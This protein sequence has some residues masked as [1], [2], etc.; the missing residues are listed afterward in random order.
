MGPRLALIRSERRRRSHYFVNITNGTR[1][2]LPVGAQALSVWL[3]A[4][5]VC[6]TVWRVS[7]LGDLWLA[8][9]LVPRASVPLN[10]GHRT[11]FTKEGEKTKLS[12]H[13]CRLARARRQEG[14]PAVRRS[15]MSLP[16]HPALRG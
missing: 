12:P 3:R 13:A 2:A 11:A 14:V 6:Y 16:S 4:H 10:Y 15:N 5:I 1:N 7:S 8:V 9:R